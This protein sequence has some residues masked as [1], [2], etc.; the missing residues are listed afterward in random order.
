[1]K[2]S[3][4]TKENSDKLIGD[5]KPSAYELH[6]YSPTKIRD[7]IEMLFDAYTW[8]KRTFLFTANNFH[9]REN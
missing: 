3:K 8:D 6:Q 9:E 1:M 5:P 4:A 2:P 7:H